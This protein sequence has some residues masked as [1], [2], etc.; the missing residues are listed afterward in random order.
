MHNNFKSLSEIIYKE[1]AFSKIVARA[2]EQE[3]VDQFGKIFPELEKVAALVGNSPIEKKLKR[4]VVVSKA[5]FKE[6]NLYCIK[7][8]LNSMY[9]HLFAFANWCFYPCQLLFR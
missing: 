5:N 8:N 1:K 3:I 6:L 9:R 2:N 4:E 7:E